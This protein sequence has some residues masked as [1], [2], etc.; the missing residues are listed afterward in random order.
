ML[1]SILRPTRLSASISLSALLALS[2]LACGDDS[3]TTGDAG[4]PDGSTADSGPDATTGDAGPDGSST[5][6]ASD[7]PSDAAGTLDAGDTCDPKNDQCGPGL[8]CCTG[9]SAILDGG[10]GHCI[11]PTDAGTC[12]LVP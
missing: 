11:T 2:A 6:A 12:P 5:D 1:L 9:G 8:K 3:T 7:A 10:T 4:T